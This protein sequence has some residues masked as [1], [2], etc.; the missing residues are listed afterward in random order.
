MQCDSIE[1]IDAIIAYHFFIKFATIW[2]VKFQKR[3]KN[4]LEN[5]GFS[6]EENQS[7]YEVEMFGQTYFLD[8]EN[9]ISWHK[10]IKQMP[11]LINK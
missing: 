6:A 5:K 9:S 10:T 11:I 8:I 7:K 4:I 2:G 3:M 1:I